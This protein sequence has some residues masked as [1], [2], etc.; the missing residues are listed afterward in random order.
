MSVVTCRPRW[1]TALPAAPLGVGLRILSQA[2]LLFR[3]SG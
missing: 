2:S 3:P 1:G